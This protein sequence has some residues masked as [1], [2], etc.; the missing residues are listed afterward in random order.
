M[1]PPFGTRRPGADVSF[2]RAALA[3][4]G[5]RGVVYSLHKSSTREHLARCAAAWG[6]GCALV[7]E[8]RFEIPATY[9]FHREASLDVAVDLLRFVKGP[10][11]REASLGALGAARSLDVGGAGGG[12]GGGGGSRGAAG[13]G[14]RGRNGGGGGG[15]GAS[16][17]GRGRR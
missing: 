9:A 6:V 3:L 1:N 4:S 5:P 8:L 11:A 13:G 12:T 10:A 2:L 16:A 14:G 15:G 7:A 17:R